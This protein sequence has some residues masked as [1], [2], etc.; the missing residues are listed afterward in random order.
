MLRILS[1]SGSVLCSRR[2]GFTTLA[3]SGRICNVQKSWTS[4]ESA[5]LPTPL[6]LLLPCPSP[7]SPLASPS[8]HLLRRGPFRLGVDLQI[9][10]SL[11]LVCQFLDI[12]PF[13]IFFLKKKH[14][15]V[16]CFAFLPFCQMKITRMGRRVCSRGA[17]QRS[18]RLG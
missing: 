14:V 2:F 10:N 9:Q 15:C 12:F 8:P 3:V 1:L 4:E 17:S 18:S 16:I 13:L 6:S 11:C 5:M 7:P